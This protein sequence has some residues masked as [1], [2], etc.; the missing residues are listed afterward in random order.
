MDGRLCCSSYVS[1]DFLPDLRYCS[2]GRSLVSLS[3][4]SW[5]TFLDLNF[6]SFSNGLSS[7]ASALKLNENIAGITL[8][9]IGNGAPEIFGALFDPDRDSEIFINEQLGGSIF[10][11]SL[12][13]GLVI[14][15]SPF[16]M[17]KS[18]YIRDVIFLIILTALVELSISDGYYVIEESVATL[19]VYFLYLIVVFVMNYYGKRA[20]DTMRDGIQVELGPQIPANFERPR[21]EE[22]YFRSIQKDIK[23]DFLASYSYLEGWSDFKF[24]WKLYYLIQVPT[25]TILMVLIPTFDYTL[26]KHGWNKLFA[27]LNLFFLP[28]FFYKEIFS[29][30]STFIAKNI[31]NFMISS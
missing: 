14:V 21:V 30:F 7:L 13:A 29:E 15:M 8:V 2:C 1:L 10:M 24:Y 22:N 6:F 31:L 3:N 19:C 11:I 17:V 18:N 26:P 4:L 5:A 28:A 20:V 27:I 25:L 23:A 12:V 9:A 16:Q